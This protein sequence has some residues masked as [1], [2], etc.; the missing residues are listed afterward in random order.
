MNDSE[1]DRLVARANPY[2]ADNLRQVPD[3]AAASELLEA[4][5]NTDAPAPRLKPATRRRPFIAI[6][7][8]AAAAVIAAASG[9]FLPENN[10]AAP[11][12]AY[13]AE[14]RAATDATPRLLID[15]PAW[16]IADIP[17]FTAKEGEIK[18]RSGRQMFQVNWRAKE[19]YGVRGEVGPRGTITLLGQTG[20]LY[21][22]GMSTDFE[23]YLP[24][25]GDYYLTIRADLGSEAKF[26]SVAAK[27][28]TVDTDTWL[29]AMPAAIVKQS[30]A[31]RVVDEMLADVPTP[32]GFDRAPLLKVLVLE[33]Y[34]F[35]AMVINAVTCT[36]HEQ[37][38]AAKKTGDKAK[39]KE[40]VTALAGS[41]SWK[42][43]QEMARRG[44]Y[45]DG[46]WDLGDGLVK[47]KDL[48]RR[49]A[50]VC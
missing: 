27:L 31:P 48:A 22:S 3:E 6:A 12:S 32:K 49:W 30:D 17:Q 18:F 36:W 13:G 44:R 8:A 10:P 26:R 21:S 14:L 41:R 5:L 47:G 4:I 33:R 1:F 16:T 29:D 37:W 45:S 42:V 28:K 35:G 25:K 19:G 9:V 50:N 2:G 23:A 39:E 24:P 11:V 38:L 46:I 40:V 34:Q 15:D 20:P 43:L 7:A